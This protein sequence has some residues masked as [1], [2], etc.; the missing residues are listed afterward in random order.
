MRVAAVA[1]RLIAKQ[2]TNRFM[3]PA[4]AKLEQTDQAAPSRGAV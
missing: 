3:E 2:N 1:T 4:M